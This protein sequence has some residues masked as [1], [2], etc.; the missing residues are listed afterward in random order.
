MS[1]RGILFSG[2]MVLAIRDRRKT[3]T[4]R[5]IDPRDP[6]DALIKVGGRGAVYDPLF[7]HHA[8]LMLEQCPYGRAKDRLYVKETFC[9]HPDHADALTMPE[10][11]G[12]HN[13]AHLLYRSDARNGMI[14]GY[15]VDRLKWRPSIFMPRWASRITLE[16]TDVM[17]ERL[18]EITDVGA[19]AE[20]VASLG[21]YV[22]LWDKINGK[23]APWASNP[24]VW[25][26]EFRVI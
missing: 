23:R 8:V 17:I 20:G 21:D 13:P 1:E 18:D 6:S 5:V 19:R 25:V 24:W 7:P 10:Y 16:V 26:V 15:D 3:Q 11:E 22:Q 12:G 2:P 14:D 4:R 9:A